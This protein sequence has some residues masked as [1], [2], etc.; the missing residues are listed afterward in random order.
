MAVLPNIGGA[1]CSSRK[2]WLTPTTRVPCSNTAKARNLLKFAGCPKPTKQ[3]QPLVSHSPYCKDT[4]RRYCCLTSF[5]RLSIHALVVKIH[6]DKVVQWCTGGDFLHPV[7][8]AS[9]VQHISDLHSKFALRPH[10][11][12]SMVD[13]QSPTAEKWRG[14]KEGRRKK[15]QGKN[16]IACR[17]TQ[18]GHN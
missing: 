1:L 11:C 2:V 7:F 8:P 9:H 4:C 10:M 18:G 16:I 14:K 13:I 12:T 5:F 6:P 15:A 17:I 3:S